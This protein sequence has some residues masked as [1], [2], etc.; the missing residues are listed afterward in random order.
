MRQVTRLGENAFQRSYLL[1]HA[2]HRLVDRRLPDGQTATL[3]SV[4]LTEQVP[5]E[6]SQSVDQE[7]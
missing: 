7:N 4:R 2:R 1:E 3:A 6:A 5:D